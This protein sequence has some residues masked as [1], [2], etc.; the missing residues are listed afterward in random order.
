LEGKRGVLAELI[1]LR[2]DWLLVAA[3]VNWWLFNF[4]PR[5]TSHNSGLALEVGCAG[6]HCP[7]RRKEV[8]LVSLPG[9]PLLRQNFGLSLDKVK[10]QR[11]AGKMQT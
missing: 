5:T 2:A 4:V 1:R 11:K 10:Q 9:I 7:G 6:L 8:S 3:F